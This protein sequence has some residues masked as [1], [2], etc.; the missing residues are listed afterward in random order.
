[1]IRLTAGSGLKWFNN[2]SQSKLMNTASRDHQLNNLRAL[3]LG[4]EGAPSYAPEG[5]LAL[6]RM[7]ID[8]LA[9]ASKL[10]RTVIYFY[11]EAK[12]RPTAPTLRRICEALGV[13]FQEA[14][15]YCTP[16]TFGRPPNRAPSG[17]DP[18]EL[19]GVNG[20]QSGQ[21]ELSKRL[22]VFERNSR[23]Q[24]KRREFEE[25]VRFATRTESDSMI[26]QEN[27]GT[28][29]LKVR[30]VIESREQVT[31]TVA[32]ELQRLM[33]QYDPP[34]SIRGLSV[35]L[36]V[37][38]EYVRR[39]VRGLVLPS[40]L[41]SREL[42]RFFGIDCEVFAA[43]VERDR[44]AREYGNAYLIPNSDP[45]LAKLASSWELLTVKQKQAL[46]SQ[47]DLFLAQNLRRVG[48]NREAIA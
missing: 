18:R 44:I 33:D 23:A 35:K 1:M 36:G 14:L 4:G 12:H 48:A 24:K 45:E 10:S 2:G 11:I 5:L 31:P 29:E 22:E 39:L 3:L 40:E 6:R 27:P 7:T 47:L 30:S 25:K 38:Y 19:S 21:V 41:A 13:S 9:G 16:A 28:T 34:L 37:S 17:S 32:S 26:E 15:N 8:E 20:D 46:L 42:A 43:L